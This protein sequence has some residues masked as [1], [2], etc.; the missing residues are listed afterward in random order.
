MW[1]IDLRGEAHGISPSIAKS[2]CPQTFGGVPD[3]LG[4]FLAGG[5]NFSG[6]AAEK[7]LYW[8]K[9]AERRLTIQP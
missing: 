3:L 7:V 5:L 6:L 9:V 4:V 8:T 2:G 1:F